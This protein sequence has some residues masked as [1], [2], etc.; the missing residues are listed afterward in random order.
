[1]SPLYQLDLSP[2]RLVKTFPT[3]GVPGLISKEG[4]QPDNRRKPDAIRYE[5]LAIVRGR[6]ADCG[7]TL[8]ADNLAE[9]RTG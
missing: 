5:A 1:M 7:Q 2:L 3:H 4:G 8:A 6:Y 9:L